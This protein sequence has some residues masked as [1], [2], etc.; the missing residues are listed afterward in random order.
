MSV[1]ILWRRCPECG[2]AAVEAEV[3]V[4]TAIPPGSVAVLH[5]PS[6]QGW[7]LRCANGHWYDVES[8]AISGGPVSYRVDRAR[9]E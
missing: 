3:G 1:S 6:R 4:E 5:R 7:Q 9:I 2:A 8:G